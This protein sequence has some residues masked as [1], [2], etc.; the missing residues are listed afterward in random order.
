MHGRSLAD[1]GYSFVSASNEAVESGQVDLKKYKV[2]DLILGKQ[3]RSV[4]GHNENRV[5]F[6]AFSPAMQKPSP[7][8]RPPGGT[9]W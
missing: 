3:R 7:I 1:L 2:V 4:L 5:D 8:I 6:E 9:S